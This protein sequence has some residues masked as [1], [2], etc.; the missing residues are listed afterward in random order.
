MSGKIYLINGDNELVEMEE[1]EYE[2]EIILQKLI[3]DYPN[4]LAGEQMDADNPRKWLL[5]SREMG[6]AFEE[7][8]SR[9]LSL[10]HLFL[11]QDGI[12]TLVEVKRSS[13]TRLRREVIGQMLDYAANAVVYLPAEE[14]REKVEAQYDLV[15]QEDFLESAVDEEKFWQSVKTN[16]QAGKVRMV[17]VADEIPNE[18][19][20]IIEFLNEQM[21][22]AEVLAVEIKQY[23]DADSKIK[24]LVPRVI[25]QTSEAQ[26]KKESKARNPLLNQKTFFENLDDHGKEFFEILF[27]FAKQ[28]ELITRWGTKG[29]SLNVDIDGNMI[30]L[31]QGY[32]YLSAY[33]QVIF[34]KVD[35]IQRKVKD[36]DKIIGEY[37][38]LLELDD[39]EKVGN[40][41]RLDVSHKLDQKQ[42]E[43]FKEILSKVIGDI[44]KNG[45][46]V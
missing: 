35:S 2:R 7:E 17:F 1:K 42:L 9:F 28:D 44:R 31:M 8:G 41:F 4:L 15:L 33:G 40:G 20:R 23:V 10:D 27:D 34:S 29:F 37:M 13:D 21:D 19:K 3:A 12:P 45:L 11:D 43:Q 25:G 6:I 5:V 32:S 14:I 36:S 46:K 22:P 18:L 24:T 38:T 16:L 30:S 39:F 26:M